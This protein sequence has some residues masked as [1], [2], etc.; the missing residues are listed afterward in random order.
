MPLLNKRHQHRCGSNV[1]D[2]SDRRESLIDVI[3]QTNL[4]YEDLESLVVNLGVL[5]ALMLS[6]NV[7]TFASFDP[8]RLILIDTK[9]CALHD[10]EF[11]KFLVFHLEKA[12]F[13]FVLPFSSNGTEI[14]Y[15]KVLLQPGQFMSF[16]SA[17]IDQEMETALEYILPS[18]PSN[19]AQAWMLK[20]NCSY[21]PKWLMQC[22]FGSTVLAAV[23]LLLSIAMYLS[24]T[25]LG[26][27][28]SPQVLHVWSMWS[29]KPVI[30]A[31]FVLFLSMVFFGFGVLFAFYVQF[32]RFYG[33]SFIG[34]GYTYGALIPLITLGILFAVNSFYRAEVAHANEVKKVGANQVE[35]VEQNNDDGS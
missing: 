21:I 9:V 35:L 20:E 27:G 12:L 13:D 26:K 10:Y 15:K 4:S 11:R 33:V 17:Y 32:P 16:P 30:V 29:L 5:A 22:G 25:F 34:W 19:I 6:T 24:L 2:Q 18:V 28:R 14:D 3:K 31:Y 7:G 8:D 1:G 23:A